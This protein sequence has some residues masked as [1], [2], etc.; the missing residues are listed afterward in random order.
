MNKIIITLA[1]IISLAIISTG[2]YLYV[3]PG[4]DSFSDSNFICSHPYNALIENSQ[5]KETITKIMG[6]A[7]EIVIKSDINEY[8]FGQGEMESKIKEGWIYT[9]NG[10]DGHIEIYFDENRIVIG[11]NCGNG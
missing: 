6:Q 2:L 5:N 11:K 7:T 4:D 9:F 8:T 3:R 10:W 1:T